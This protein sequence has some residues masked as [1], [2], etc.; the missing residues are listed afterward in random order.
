MNQGK[1]LGSQMGRWITL[2]VLAAVTAALLMAS[3][4]R[5]Q[6]SGTIEF[7]ENSDDPVAIFSATDPEDDTPITW[8]IAAAGTDPDGADGPLATEDAA[9]AGD[10]QISSTGIL[11]FNIDAANDGSSSGSPDF[12]NPRGGGDPGTSNTYS[13]VVQGSDPTALGPANTFHKVVV[14][15]TNVDENGVVTWTVDPDGAGTALDTTV[16]GGDPI[17][18]FQAGATLVASVSDG[19]LAGAAGAD[20]AGKVVANVIWRWY[21][22]PT[23]SL[24]GGTLIDG[25][26][27]AT[28]TV[29]DM[30]GS[31]DVGLYL[32][33]EASYTDGSGPVVTASR[34]SDYPVQAFRVNNDVPTFG[35]DTSTARSVS[36]GPSGMMVGAPVTATDGNGDV[37]NYTLF[38]A[39][40]TTTTGDSSNF[41]IDQ[42]TGR[43]TTAV[44]LDYDLPEIGGT[45]P[46]R[47]FTVTVRATDSAGAATEPSGDTTEPDLPDDMTVT[48]TL[49]N[50]NERPA[51]SPTTGTDTEAAS[52]N[53]GSGSIAEDATG[54]GLQVA[55]YT[56]IDLDADDTVLLSLRGDDAAMFQ[57]AADTVADGH[58]ATQILSF[59][60]SRNYEDPKD[61][62]GDNVYEVTVRA[63]DGGNLYNDKAV[64]VRVTNV[65]EAPSIMANTPTSYEFAE[66]SDEDVGTF[67]ATD[68]EGANIAWS[69]AAGDDAEDFSINATTGVL[70]FDIDTAQD[71]SSPGSPDFENA[72][73]TGADNTYNVTVQ[74]SDDSATP[75]VGTLAVAVE[76]TNVNEDGVVT[77]TVSPRNAGNTDNLAVATVNGG[78]PIV[79]FQDG[80]ILAASATDGDVSGNVKA[81]TITSWQWYRSSSSS[82]CGSN[83]L[84]GNGADSDTYTVQDEDR[85]SYLC[86][87][88]NYS[89]GGTE[90][91]A[92]KVSDYRVGRYLAEN[93]ANPTFGADTSTARMVDEGASGMMVGDPVTATDADSAASLGDRLN[94]I[95]FDGDGTSTTGDS[96]KFRI[97]QENGQITTAVRLNF[98]ADAGAAD[99]CTVQNSCVV[100]VRATDSA[101]AATNETTTDAIPDNMEVTIAIGDVNEAPTWDTPTAANLRTAIDT[102]EGQAVLTTNANVGDDNVTFAATDND[103]PDTAILVLAGPDMDMFELSATGVLSFT[104]MPDYENPMDDGEDN[105]YHVIVR[106][107]DGMLNADRM[108]AVNVTDENEGP[109]LTMGGLFLSGPTSPEYDENGMDAVATYMATGSDAASAT[110]SV[111]GA[112]AS[113]FMV[114]GSGESAMLMFRN[115]PDFEAMASDDGDSVYEVTVNASDGTYDNMREVMV[116]VI[117]MDEPGMVTVMPM[118]P[119]AGN[120]VTAELSDP[121]RDVINITWQWSMSADGTD[122]SFTDIDGATMDSYTPDSAMYLMATATY[123]D[124]H[125]SQMEMSDAIQVM[126]LMVSGMDSV[127]YAE[128]GTG[129]VATYSANVSGAT[130]SLMDN[131]MDDMDDLSISSSGVLTFNASPDFEMPMDG[132]GMN[133]YMVTVM[134][135]VGN[136]TDSMEVTVMVTNMN[137]APMFDMSMATLE[138]AEDT[139]AG[140]AIGAAFPEAMDPDAR[141]SLTYSL[142]GM[143]AASF[144]FDA[145]TRQIMTSAALDYETK[146]SYSVMVMATDMGGLTDSI[147]VTINV[148]D[149][150]EGPVQR[151]DTDGTPGISLPEMFNAIDDYFEGDIT[152]SEMF[153]VIDAYFG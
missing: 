11:T 87:K 121:D 34:V 100:T 113:A 10:F 119:V 46:D 84:S 63:S 105:R 150:E 65:D 64:T 98:E 127:S 110:W 99:N 51:F 57:L 86:A 123:R 74:A 25:A 30:T 45:A 116:T 126:D 118:N 78:T 60:T 2:A 15:V 103:A 130:W 6:D 39:D 40:G 55:T 22:S 90:F 69:L 142:G 73:D 56:A 147:D 32:R 133:D 129:A 88:A 153:E 148:T 67:T 94:Y 120:A 36:E 115:S 49:S 27:S 66:N 114:Q 16:N 152:L 7:P 17:V 76:V 85:G 47:S 75:N 95:L 72:Q 96:T 19:D 143:D 141:D 146:D 82:S 42:K 12:E 21:R 132:D 151:Y 1:I 23:N 9:D 89:I 5:A 124:I 29:Q 131:D 92:E 52:V 106:A 41:R 137:E 18:Q 140:M 14:E 43:I 58:T 54:T 48:I 102:P 117:D 101:G 91:S 83:A 109:D 38:D 13:V 20:G 97:N 62:D 80:A 128:N 50:V 33:A 111:T 93:N 24:T 145:S 125:D 112:D 139:A 135:T 3:V 61:K 4:V 68:P 108:I 144:G 134:A 53:L 31:D 26:N 149:V 35:A 59:R 70:S 136:A 107:T 79:Q 37:L 71:G 122:G 104:T 8:A 138:V 44:A 77:W 28:Y 81:V